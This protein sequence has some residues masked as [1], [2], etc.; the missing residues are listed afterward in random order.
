MFIDFANLAAETTR[1]R[2]TLQ[3]VKDEQLELCKQ[4]IAEDIDPGLISAI[5]YLID[6]A[7]ESGYDGGYSDAHW[8]A[9]GM[10]D[11]A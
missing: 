7:L 3:E 10:G 8:Y 9:K 2:L 11:G 1:K 5:M 4:L 6:D